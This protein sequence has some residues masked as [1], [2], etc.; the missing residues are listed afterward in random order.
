M[1][2]ARPTGHV[3][4]LFYDAWHDS[5]ARKETD[6]GRFIEIYPSRSPRVPTDGCKWGWGSTGVMF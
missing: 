1:K 2:Y 6:S 3:L 5:R 4:K